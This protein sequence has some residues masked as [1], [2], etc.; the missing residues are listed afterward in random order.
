M[1]VLP[2]YVQFVNELLN[3]SIDVMRS[4]EDSR[5]VTSMVDSSLSRVILHVMK[6]CTWLL[7]IP[8]SNSKRKIP[9]HFLQSKAVLIECMR[10]LNSLLKCVSAKKENFFGAYKVN[11]H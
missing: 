4:I 2:D 9:G 6:V 5:N 11:I 8:Q 7:P 10:K 1:E 3:I